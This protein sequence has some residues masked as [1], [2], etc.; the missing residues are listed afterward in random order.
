MSF[1]C[2]A[3]CTCWGPRLNRKIFSHSQ[4]KNGITF[5]NVDFMRVPAGGVYNNSAQVHYIKALFRNDATAAQRTVISQVHSINVM[6]DPTKAHYIYVMQ[7]YRRRYCR[8]EN[9]HQSK[10]D[11]PMRYIYVMQTPK[12]K[13][14]PNNVRQGQTQKSPRLARAL[15][16]G[17]G[18]GPRGLQHAQVN[19]Q[20]DQRTTN[21]GQGFAFLVAQRLG[22]LARLVQQGQFLDV[23]ARQ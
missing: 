8:P 19:A 23:S 14:P 11:Q 13:A 1:I 5:P 17:R 22:P 15:E 10:I 2:G 4:F 18:P 20:G 7:R 3:D 9:G 12:T 16:G 21:L 6:Q